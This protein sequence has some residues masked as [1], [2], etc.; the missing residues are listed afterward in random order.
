M[1][2]DYKI[3][4]ETSCR[5]DFMNV[6]VELLKKEKLNIRMPESLVSGL[7]RN[8]IYYVGNF[9]DNNNRHC[10]RAIK[11]INEKQGQT[12][13]YLMFALSQIKNNSSE[14]T[15]GIIIKT[16]D[17]NNTHCELATCLSEMDDVYLKLFGSGSTVV[18]NFIKP[19]GTKASIVRV[20]Y[21]IN[22]DITSYIITNKKMYPKED[23]KN[24]L[25]CKLSES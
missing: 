4:N 1:K 21:T 23:I 7:D 17:A 18:Q 11:L 10:S 22:N 19:K 5:I 24:N 2:Q 15:P 16:G 3:V 6:L 12:L 14:G 25:E 13:L 9:L 8:T 20:M